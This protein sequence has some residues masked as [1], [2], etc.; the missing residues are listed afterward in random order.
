MDKEKIYFVLRDKVHKL[1][2]ITDETL[3][4]VLKS[5]ET[6]LQWRIA[7]EA[8]KKEWLPSFGKDHPTD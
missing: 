5:R 8:W 2:E 6:R 3:N 1:E 4:S 7:H